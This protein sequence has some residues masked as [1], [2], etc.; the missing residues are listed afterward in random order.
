MSKKEESSNKKYTHT[1]SINLLIKTDSEDR[2][3]KEQIA[4]ALKSYQDKDPIYEHV[5]WYEHE[6][7]V[8]S[9]EDDK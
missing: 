4:E 5:E 1:I 3:T 6:E 2:P 8:G 7:S 9:Y